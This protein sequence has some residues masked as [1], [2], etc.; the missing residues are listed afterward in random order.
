MTIETAMF[1]YLSGKSTITDIVSTRIYATIA[2]SSVVYPHI[3]FKILAEAPEHDMEGAIGLTRVLMQLDAWAFNVAERQNIAEALRK[4]LDGFTGLM[5]SEELV[6]RQCL[7][8]N[9]TTFDEPDPHGRNLPV[10]RSSLDFAIWHVES[11][12]TL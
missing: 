8:E 12:P 2:P 3:T 1:S 10:F 6:I 4:A 5:G 7:M 11:L 9:R